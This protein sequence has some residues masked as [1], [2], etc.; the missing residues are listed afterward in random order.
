MPAQP[1][2]KAPRT[3]TCLPWQLPTRA[4]VIS[5]DHTFTRDVA[6]SLREDGYAVMEASP[7][8]ELHRYVRQL[9]RPSRASRIPAL[10]IVDLCCDGGSRQLVSMIVAAMRW[11]PA[12][13]FVIA[14]H[15]GVAVPVAFAPTAVFYAPFDLDDL[16]TAALHYARPLAQTSAW[17]SWLRNEELGG[18]K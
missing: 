10:V 7:S 6:H 11:A 12:A 2:S 13:L 8:A 14:P 1:R 17:R 16:R 4:L 18:S 9:G 5:A 3:T 15:A